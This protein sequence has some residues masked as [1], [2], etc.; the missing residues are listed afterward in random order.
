MSSES[1]LVTTVLGMPSGT[2][3]GRG[4]EQHSQPSLPDRDWAVPVGEEL[5]LS[6]TD[7]V[8]TDGFGLPTESKNEYSYQGSGEGEEGSV[9]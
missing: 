9:A 6:F 2:A 7:A 8:A 1:A 4:G 5:G 3:L